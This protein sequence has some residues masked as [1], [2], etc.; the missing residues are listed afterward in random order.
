MKKKVPLQVLEILEPYVNKNATNF[1]SIDPDKCLLRLIDKDENSDFYF[2]I[3]EYKADSSL[4]LRIDFKPKSKL[5]IDRGYVW[6]RANLLEHYFSNWLKILEG[7]D[8]VSTAFDDPILKT[9]EEEYF[10]MFEIIDEDAGIQPFST[11][12]ILLLDAYLETIHEGI[13]KYQRN[14]NKEE[15]HKIKT[16]VEELRN[17][18]TKNSKKWVVR[19]LSKVWAQI[20]KLGP[21]IMKEFIFDGQLHLIKEGVKL[22]LNNL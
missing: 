21:R 19:Q 8:K 9:F 20:S 15:I 3:V 18:I 1:K 4:Q 14:E 2:N 6:I 7:Y 11:K 17:N 10:S 16:D 12:Q 13:D 5:S 22:L